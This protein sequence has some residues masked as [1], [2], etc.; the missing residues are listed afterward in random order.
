MTELDPDGNV[1]NV[2]ISPPKPIVAESDKIASQPQP[3]PKK[4]AGIP[5]SQEQ[6][7]PS[8]ES[9]VAQPSRS[10]GAN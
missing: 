2:Y 8:P 5:T 1:N 4:E 7:N 9:S 3:P 6:L 10:T